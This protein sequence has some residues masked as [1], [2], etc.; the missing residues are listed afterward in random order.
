M[1]TIQKITPDAVFDDFIEGVVDRLT[2][3]MINTL[4][5]VGETCLT[6]ARLGGNYRDRTG[7]LRS[8]IGYV[9]VVDGKIARETGGNAG[10]GFA[11]SMV[12]EFPTGIVLVMATGMNYSSYVAA[13]G[14]NVI[15]SAEAMAE[16]L[17]PQIM[18]DLDFEIAA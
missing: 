16:R 2:E 9:I 8:S 12:R 4:G 7:N 5:Y 15:D 10:R 17:V 18:K 3:A 11:R 14:Y 6:E 1:A 13:K